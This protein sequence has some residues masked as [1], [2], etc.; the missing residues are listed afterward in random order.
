M[1]MMKTW[2]VGLMSL[3]M[4]FVACGKSNDTT[5]DEGNGGGGSNTNLPIKS[6]DTTITVMQS[7]VYQ[8]KGAYGAVETQT[9][10]NHVTF[11]I[12]FKSSKDGKITKVRAK[13]GTNANY[14]IKL[15]NFTSGNKTPL[16]QS[17]KTTNTT[18]YTGENT[19]S[20]WDIKKDTVYMI[21]ITIN[22][23]KVQRLSNTNAVSTASG[24]IGSLTFDKNFVYHNHTSGSNGY[25]DSPG[26]IAH[27]A[28][29]LDFDFVG[30]NY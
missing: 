14:D 6:Y 22:K 3:S 28:G 12:K 24:V 18:L 25:P 19:V 17:V 1:T 23:G 7:L 20:G 5:P 11:A 16:V 29:Y 13:T 4:L 9:E 10:N 2:L 21:G 8:F 26:R 15:W 30:Y 27:F